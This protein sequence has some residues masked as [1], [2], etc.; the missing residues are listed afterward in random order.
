MNAKRIG[1]LLVRR[2]GLLQMMVGVPH[3]HPN[4][5]ALPPVEGACL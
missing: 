3:D 4:H 5:R 2:L 1:A